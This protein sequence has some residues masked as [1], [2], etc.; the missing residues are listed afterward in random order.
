MLEQ[1]SRLSTSLQ[2]E[3]MSK[4]ERFLVYL[5]GYVQRKVPQL[6]I[7]LLSNDTVYFE[8]VLKM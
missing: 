5:K 7:I 6:R 4:N 3:S 8:H 1:A 2:N